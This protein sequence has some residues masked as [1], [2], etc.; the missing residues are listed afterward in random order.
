MFVE[1]EIF[2]ATNSMIFVKK[3]FFE[4]LFFEK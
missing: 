2:I 1:F 4:N 3:D